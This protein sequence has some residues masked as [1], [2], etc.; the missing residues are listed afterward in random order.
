MKGEII[1]QGRGEGGGRG[2]WG[3]EDG[4]VTWSTVLSST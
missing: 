1:G 2:R 3:G 4:D